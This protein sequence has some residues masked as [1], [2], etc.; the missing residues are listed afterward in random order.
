MFFIGG[1]KMSQNVASVG[2]NELLSGMIIA[3]DVLR[4]GS[5]LIK[6]GSIINEEIIDRLQNMFFLDKLQVY[7]STDVIEKNTKEA[8][9][10][11]VE[12][13]FQEVSAELGNLY[14]HI[15]M[16]KED[17]I[18]DLR[19]F[20]WKIQKQFKNSELVINSVLFQGSGDDCIYRH[21]VNVAALSALLGKWAGFD[22]EKINLL[23][24]SA[25]LHDFGITKLSDE[26]QKKPDLELEKEAEEVKEHV[27]L[28]YQAMESLA[29]LDKS[30][31][32]G[33]L[34]HHERCDGSGYPLGLANEKIHPF[35]KIIAIADEIDV[36]NSNKEL[37]EQKG[38]FHVLKEIKEKS[39]RLLDYKYS[40]IFLEH[41][42]NFYIGEEVLLS[43]GDVAKIL[44]MN[45]DDIESPLL[46]KDGDFINLKIEKNIHIKELVVK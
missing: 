8:E 2:V 6:E 36:L 18:E 4:N 33:V 41:I 3:K 40:R 25:L 17:S 42:S 22:E 21:G 11:K 14:S 44:Q 43:N 26:L 10:K 46:L 34:M 19:E 31:L 38:A 29:C 1:N 12:Q 20:S 32:C 27:R 39:L 35:A 15:E 28:G 23:I 16:L 24:Y 45:V 13:A 30:V 37:K 5:V 9:I 7:I